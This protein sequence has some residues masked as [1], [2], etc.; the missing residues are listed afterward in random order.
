MSPTP[1]GVIAVAVI[2]P[3]F[4]ACAVVGRFSARRMK[5]VR[6]QS[7]DWTIALALVWRSNV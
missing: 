2:L 3:A 5:R 7:D 6:L 1:Q 4:A